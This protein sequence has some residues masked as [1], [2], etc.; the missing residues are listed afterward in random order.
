MTK[1]LVEDRAAV[2]AVPWTHSGIHLFEAEPQDH[3]APQVARHGSAAARGW[4]ARN[5]GRFD[6]VHVEG[7]YLWQHLPRE[8]PPALL[9]EQ[10]VEHEL[11]RQRGNFAAAHATRAAEHAVWREADLLAAVTEEDRAHIAAQAR[12]PVALVTDGAD[13][14][15]AWAGAGPSRAVC[16]VGSRPTVVFVGNFGYEPNVDAA[17]WLVDEI[18]PLVR[19]RADARLVLVGN[20][21]PP[22][23]VALAGDDVEVTGRVPAV[24]PWLDA[25][26]VVVCPL[27]IGGGVKVKVLE[28]L[29]RGC[30]IVAT[31][32]CAHGITGAR[33]A[34]RIA[35]DAEPFANAVAAALLDPVER[36]RMEGAALRLA[37]RLPSW[38][39]V[40][41]R[42]AELWRELAGVREVAA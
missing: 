33:E 6:V 35:D 5:V 24:E 26:T 12:R 3:D 17:H 9:V 22:D 13:H 28:A 30:A 39:S 31:P 14:E 19:R 25:A 29:R 20:A 34:M 1:T 27:R 2:G 15:T 11:W 16:R 8:R 32:Q 42:L 10:N 38:D 40:A 23:V 21:P 7:F 37:A 36:A 41:A 18:F 4:L